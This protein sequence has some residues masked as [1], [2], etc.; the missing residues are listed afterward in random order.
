[1]TE[2]AYAAGVGSNAGL[3]CADRMLPCLSVRQPWASLIIAAG[4]DI[5]NRSWPT[6]LR[7]RVLIHAAKGMTRDEHADAIAFAVRA[8][9]A[10]P[11][12]AGSPRRTTLRDLGF[13]FGELPRGAIIGSVEIV[14][15]V[16]DSDSPWFVGRYGFVLRDPRPLPVFPYRGALGLFGVPRAALVEAQPNAELCGAHL[17]PDEAADYPASARTTG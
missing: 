3:G 15:C 12:N 10:D 8:I 2:R 7:G 9:N 16:T 6:R 17:A 4:K 5:E 11:R 1:M 14:D 13:A